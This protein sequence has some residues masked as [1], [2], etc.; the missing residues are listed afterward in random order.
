[1]KKLLPPLAVLLAIFLLALGNG[2][3]VSRFTQRWQSQVSRSSAL[4]VQENW[5]GAWQVL[6]ESYRDWSK[7]QAYLHIVLEHEVIDDAEAMYHR[8]MAF[9]LAEEPSE[10]RA[11]TADL[12]AQLSLLAEMERFSL[13]NVL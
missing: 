2:L 12:C 13:K 8:A 10:F 3:I 11:E 4:A 9:A 6:E 5:D 1:M 7:P